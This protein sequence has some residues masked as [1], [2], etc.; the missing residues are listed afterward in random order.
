[1]LAPV[2]E[3][4]DLVKALHRAGIEVNP[5]VVFNHTTER[6]AQVLN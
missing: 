3:F 1:M 5:D 2:R 4:C 6:S